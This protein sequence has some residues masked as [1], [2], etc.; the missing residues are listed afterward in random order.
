M[1]EYVSSTAP[2]LLPC[3]VH[4]GGKKSLILVSP[5]NVTSYSNHGISQTR[6]VEV[7]KPPQ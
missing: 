6:G 1:P 3:S 7:G 5:P 2:S 4:C